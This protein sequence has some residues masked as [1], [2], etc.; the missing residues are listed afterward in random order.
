MADEG[1]GDNTYD[2]TSNSYAAAAAATTAG[3]QKW[4]FSSSTDSWQLDDVLQTG[5]DLGTPYSVAPDRQGDQYPTGLNNTDS[6]TGLPWAPATD[7][8]R[9]LTGRVSPKRHGHAVG[10]HLDGERLRRPGR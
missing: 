2:A 7:G 3:L 8:L 4:S 9:G 1:A 5:L 6:G 10:L